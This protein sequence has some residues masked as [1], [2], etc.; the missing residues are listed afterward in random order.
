VTTDHG[1]P[2]DGPSTWPRA[3]GSV[4][5]ADDGR[6]TWQRAARPV[7]AADAGRPWVGD[8]VA[9]FVLPGDDDHVGNV[10]Q[11]SLHG[12]V[13]AG[14][15]ET[16]AAQHV[17]RVVGAAVETVSFG[18][19]FVEEARTDDLRARSTVVRRGRRFVV[20]R[21]DA[22]QDAPPRAVAIGHG[23]FRVV[24]VR[25]AGNVP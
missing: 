12:G 24:Q 18:T 25:D 11:N 21:I 7:A 3:A 8:D 16:A 2:A 20:A 13:I 1:G 15:L 10:E 6:S 19:E 22:W 14:F 23:I 9:D 4:A 5:P 17:E